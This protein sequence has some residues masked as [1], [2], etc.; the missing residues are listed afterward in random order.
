MVGE[1]GHED[2]YATAASLEK[3]TDPVTPIEPEV[4]TDTRDMLLAR[5]KA[6]AQQKIEQQRREYEKSLKLADS[7]VSQESA[8]PEESTDPIKQD[9]GI[10]GTDEFGDRHPSATIAPDPGDQLDDTSLTM[11]EQDYVIRCI[12]HK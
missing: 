6:E 11:K 2:T 9:L 1:F 12:K 3:L 10:L 5:K 8:I 4:D 7:G